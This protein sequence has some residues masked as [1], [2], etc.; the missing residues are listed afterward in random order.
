MASEL[1]NILLSGLKFIVDLRRNFLPHGLRLI[2]WFRMPAG[3]RVTTF[4]A[5]VIGLRAHHG[6]ACLLMRM[7]EFDFMQRLLIETSMDP[8][9]GL[10]VACLW[11][12][13]GASQ[14]DWTQI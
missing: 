11:S 10:V 14:G 1:C 12:Y 7:P 5:S 4:V 3:S 9:R 8:L 6:R 2:Q 13:K